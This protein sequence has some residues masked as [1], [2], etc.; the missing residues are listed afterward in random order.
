VA[1]DEAEAEGKFDVGGAA[2]AG[3]EGGEEGE[4]E[5][6]GEGAGG[7]GGAGG[8][9]GAESC[10]RERSKRCSWRLLRS[11]LGTS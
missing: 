8:R 6:E 3:E 2:E 4:G 5:E 10:T 9:T 11:F 7:G 1:G